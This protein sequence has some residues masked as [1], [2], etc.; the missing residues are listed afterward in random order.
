MV[1]VNVAFVRALDAGVESTVTRVEAPV[2]NI[3]P[4]AGEP[5]RF[6]FIAE[7]TPVLL[8]TAVRTGGDYGVTVSASNV[9]ESIEFLSNELTFWGVPGAKAHDSARGRP[10]LKERETEASGQHNFGAV[11]HALEEQHPSAFLSLPTSC[12][13]RPL[14]SSVEGDSWEEPDHLFAPFFT[15][16]PMVT[17]DGCNRLPFEPSIKATSDTE[18]ASRPMGL[19]IDVHVNQDSILD[20][21]GLA[22]S[23]VR[24]VTVALPEEVAVN[25][26]AGGGLEACSKGLVGFRGFEDAAAAGEH[27]GAR[28]RRN[29]AVAAG[30]ELLRQRVEDRR[31]H[32]PH[33]GAA[34]S[35]EGVCV[36]RGAGRKPVRV[37]S[38]DVHRRRRPG[39]GYAG[40]ARGGGGADVVWADHLDVRKQPPDPV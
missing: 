32:D 24:D 18:Q 33:A 40:Q 11:C 29:R 37:A 15:S 23:A 21:E 38:G 26:A 4:E 14:E 19:N 20:P 8:S 36:S 17:L 6:G 7:G 9:P 10:C 5:A 25:A 35:A 27:R 3:E 12:T 34:Q 16:T 22:E 28:G 30:P 39:V 31:S 1:G 13:G 2:Y